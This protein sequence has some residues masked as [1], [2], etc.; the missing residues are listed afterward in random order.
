MPTTAAAVSSQVVSMPRMRMMVHAMVRWELIFRASRPASPPPIVRRAARD[1]TSIVALKEK[2]ARM[3][4]SPAFVI[5]TRG[6]PLALAQA[7]ETQR[8][9]IDAHGLPPE[10]LPLQIIK[11]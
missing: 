8:R 7:H 5:G 9:L 2:T 6:S 4:T 10:R 11:T 3:S 1:Q